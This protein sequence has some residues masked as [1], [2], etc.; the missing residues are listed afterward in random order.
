MN[1]P[2][3]VFLDTSYFVALV[4]LDDRYHS[5]AMATKDQ[6]LGDSTTCVTTEYILVE[7]LDGLS[8]LRFRALGLA[9]VDEILADSTLEVVPA[10][11][12]LFEQGLQLYRD[13][14]DKEWGLTDCISFCVMED[15]GITCA[16]T[17]DRH[18]VQ[19]GYRALLLEDPA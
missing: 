7:L 3:A 16:L 19:A 8:R 4:N 11:E 6:L 18:F 1:D 13:R 12:R 5:T 10:G 17:A 14:L 2:L 9:M 15:R